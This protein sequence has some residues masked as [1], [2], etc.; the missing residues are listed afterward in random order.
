MSKLANGDDNAK[1]RIKEITDELI[2]MRTA[3]TFKRKK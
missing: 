3:R 1:T 2:Q